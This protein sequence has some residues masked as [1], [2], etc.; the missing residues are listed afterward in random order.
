MNHH[1]SPIFRSTWAAAAAL[2][3]VTIAALATFFAPRTAAAAEWQTL[4]D[5]RDVS[6]WSIFGKPA[7]TPVTWAIEDGAL[8]WRKGGGNLMTKE[9]FDNFEL[10]LEWKVS[11]GSNSG[12]LF[13]V[14][15]ASER[16][17]FSG[18]EIQILDDSRHKDGKKGLTSSGSLYAL[19]APSKPAVKPVGE[20]NKMRLRVQGNRVQNWLNG[21]LVVDAEI[22]SADWNQRVAASK[23]AKSPQFARASSG[24]ILLQDH[25]NPVWFRNIRIRRL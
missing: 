5:G 7:G 20:W 18:P 11:P 10:E 16:P 24:V 25:G 4:F 19:Y 1:R 6:A 22:G 21:E 13:R 2:P 8:A 17:P 9:L 23:F 12:I 14:D 3:A 15:P